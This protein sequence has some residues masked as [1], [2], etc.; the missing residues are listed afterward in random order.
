MLNI[1]NSSSTSLFPAPWEDIIARQAPIT[2]QDAL[3]WCEYVALTNQT[4]SSA[5]RKLVSFFV[6]EVEVLDV[7]RKEAQKI[8]DYIYDALYIENVLNSI[9][10]DYLVYGNSFVTIWNPTS[11]YVSCPKCGYGSSFLP[12]ATNPATEFKFSEWK[13]NFKCL[14]CGFTGA[15]NIRDTKSSKE[16][17]LNII[18]WNVHDI[19]INYDL[20]SGR[21]QFVYII[22][23]EYKSIIQSGS[24]L[25]LNSAPTN[26]LKAIKENTDYLFDDDKI[27]HLYEPALAGVRVNGWGLSPV[28]ANFRQTWYIE[29]LRRANQSIA[30]DYIVPLRILAPEPRASVPEFGDPTIISNMSNVS[31]QLQDIIRDWRKD[32][33]GWYSCPFPIRYQVLGAEGNRIIPAQ[34]MEQANLDLIS[35]LGLPVEFFKGSLTMQAAPVA[36]RLLEGTWSSVSRIL[37]TFLQHLANA[38]STEFRW[39]SFKLKLAKPTHIDDINKQMAKLQLA[40]QGAISLSTGLK[41]IGVDFEQE[42]RQVLEDQ[43]LQAELSKEM[44]EEM[45][46]ADLNMLMSMPQQP[47]G[48]MPGMPMPGMPAPGGGAPPPMPG[49]MPSPIPNDPIAQ[50]LSMI[51]DTTVQQVSIQDLTAIAQQMAQQLFGMHPSLRIS[52]L[53]KIQQK[54]EVIHALVNK[55]LDV[56][57]TRAAL[58]GKIQAQQMAAQQAQGRPQT[59]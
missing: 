52:A 51:P 47:Q 21:K 37:N 59:F 16:L 20:F 27:I 39:D 9:G 22:P 48:P 56:M 8:K 50:L 13:F 35:A 55:Y 53:R 7:E 28:L 40:M 41:N 42:A 43:K 54:N 23:G 3:Y 4:L 32:P 46:A 31:G 36:L 33:T 57:S 18:R 45:Q 58:E 10:L 17:P 49:S 2:I 44:Q 12:Y 34:I 24:V 5:L 14:N 38:L 11:R 26:L 15:F 30:Y 1:T 29:I 6:T 25:H 19:V